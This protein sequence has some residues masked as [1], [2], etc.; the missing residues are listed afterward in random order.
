LQKALSPDQSGTEGHSETS[1]PDSQNASG[2]TASTA[3]PVKR[4]S[5]KRAG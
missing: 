1:E 5:G 4:R 2:Q 3:S